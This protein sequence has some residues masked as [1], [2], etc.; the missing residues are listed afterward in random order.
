MET[1]YICITLFIV[2]AILSVINY[3]KRVETH[4]Q[5]RNKLAK[6][7]VKNNGDNDEIIKHFVGYEYPFEMF[8]ALN[9]C[10]Y[11]TF[12]SPTIASVYR[13]TGTIYNTPDKR[14]CDTDLLMHIWMDYGL[15]STEGKASYEHLNKIHGLHSSKTRNVD[16]VFVLCCLVV[17]AIQFTNDYGWRR[18]EEKEKQAMW[19]FYR[20]VG[21]RMQLT[22]IPENLQKCYEFVESYTED[23]RQARVTE[24]GQVLTEAITKLV[25]QWYYLLPAFVCRMAV[26]VVLYQMGATFQRKLGLSKPSIFESLLINTVLI[27]RRSILCVIPPRSVPYKLSD[28]I[29]NTDY[30]CPVSKQ[31]I[32][33]VG[34]LDMLAKIQ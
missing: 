27:T 28:V 11:R 33:K 21:Q 4:V 17:D 10:F 34:P 29:M 31:T 16:F 24:D 25:C 5:W 19:E 3:L 7:D 8:L 13:K 32:T 23:N 26:K 6:L 1:I 2:V 9:F 30:G 18:P 20:R 14:A 12:C 22:N 15:D